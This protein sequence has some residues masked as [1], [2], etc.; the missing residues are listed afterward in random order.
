MIVV[1]LHF[2]KIQFSVWCI[3]CS[4]DSNFS[5]SCRSDWFL[6]SEE[7]VDLYPQKSNGYAVIKDTR[8]DT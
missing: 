2:T 4:I 5:D 6:A 3:S 8:R 1:S 7:E